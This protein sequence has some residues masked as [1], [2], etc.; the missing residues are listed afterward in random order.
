MVEPRRRCGQNLMNDYSKQMIFSPDPRR[1][2]PV[3]AM[4]AVW[5]A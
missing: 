4:I 1:D 5:S 3:K 2:W